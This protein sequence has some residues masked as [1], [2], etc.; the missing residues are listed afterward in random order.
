M[1]VIKSHVSNIFLGDPSPES[2]QMDLVLVPKSIK[3]DKP[4]RVTLIPNG[5]VGGIPIGDNAANIPG[6][7]PGFIM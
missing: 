2:P 6:N 7:F 1:K 3:T 4:T 5:P